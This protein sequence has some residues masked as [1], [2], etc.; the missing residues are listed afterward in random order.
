MAKLG[1]LIARLKSC[2]KDFSFDELSRLLNNLNF[3]EIGNSK[4]GGSRRKFYHRDKN[5]MINLHKPHPS[6]YLKVYAIKQVKEKLLE[7]GLI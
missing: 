3:E 1:K 5:I 7:E 4:T 6:P 2:P